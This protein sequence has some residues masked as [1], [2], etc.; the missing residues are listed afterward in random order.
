MRQG[1]GNGTDEAWI[2]KYREAVKNAPDKK[3]RFQK[4]K[5]IASSCF[6]AISSTFSSKGK[7]KVAA[8]PVPRPPTQNPAATG[9]KSG[10]GTAQIASK[11]VPKRK[12]G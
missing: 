6:N 7:G 1:E 12:I 4:I 9:K 2:A 8:K 3:S 11:N 10:S 5:K